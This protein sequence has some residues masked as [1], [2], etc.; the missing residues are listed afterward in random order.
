MRKLLVFTAFGSAVGID[1]RHGDATKS[2]RPHI[3]EERP[4]E[5][6]AGLN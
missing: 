3:D 6:P 5:C 4:K 1:S 2:G